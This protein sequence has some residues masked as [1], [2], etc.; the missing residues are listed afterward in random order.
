[1]L[2]QCQVEHQ[3][4]QTLMESMPD[5]IYVKDRESRFTAVNRAQALHAGYP[6]PADLLGKTDFDLY[7]EAFAQQLHAEEQA[8][9]RTGQAVIGAVEDLSARHGRPFWLQSTKVPIVRDGTIVGLVGISRDITEFK[10]TQERLAHLALHDP[11]T[12]LPNRA[13]LMDRLEQAVRVC[14]REHTS[15]AFCLLDLDRFKEVNDT[16]GHQFGDRLLQEVAARLDGVLRVSDTA[17]RLGGDEFALLLPGST[18][19]GAIALAA[20]ICQTLAQPFDLDGHHPEIVA[21][22]GI[23]QCPLH[24]A[25][26]TT[27]LAQVDVAMYA[28][29]QAGCGYTVYDPTLQEHSPEQLA[30]PHEFRAALA[31]D[32]L[33]LEYQPL[34]AFTPEQVPTV[35]AL[36]RWSHPRFGAIPPARILPLAERLGLTMPLFLWTLHTALRQCRVWHDRGL[37]LRVAVNIAPGALRDAKLPANV[38]QMLGE[39]ALPASSLML[40]LTEGAL[41]VDPEQT[42]T[43]LDNLHAMGVHLVLD[44][45][46]TGFASLAYLKNIPVQAIKLDKSFVLGMVPGNRDEAI[47]RSVIDLSHVLGLAVVAEGIEDQGTLSRLAELGCDSGQGFYMSKPVPVRELEDW[48]ESSSWAPMELHLPES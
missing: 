13:L 32:E 2:E 23:V 16:L 27:L 43:V 3:V 11:L 48:L 20:R 42:L 5:Q 7:T 8:A 26:V 18:M 31:N 4:L 10:L 17:A 21:S 46:G 45:F 22:I 33:F 12:G 6:D 40:E 30:L 1:M 19:D 14:E 36:L 9:M 37:G 39:Y 25:D 44:D 35:E 47:V 29:K 24:S 34:V 15:F 41:M 38:A 28:A